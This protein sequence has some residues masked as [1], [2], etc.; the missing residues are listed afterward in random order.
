MN[1]LIATK[2]T[3]F[4]VKNLIWKTQEPV[5]CIDEFYQTFMK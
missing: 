2:E 1:G 3:E 4:V 5:S